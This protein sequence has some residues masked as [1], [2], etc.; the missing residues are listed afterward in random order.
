MFF[1]ESASFLCC[2]VDPD[3][4]GSTSALLLAAVRLKRARRRNSAALNQH[5]SYALAARS[6]IVN[7]PAV[8][9]KT[10]TVL[11]DFRKR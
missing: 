3:S 4:R 11:E 1:S 2:A 10:S 9:V 5:T 6:L 8:S 7:V